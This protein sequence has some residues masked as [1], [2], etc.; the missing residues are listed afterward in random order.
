LT[1]RFELSGGGAGTIL[2]AD[3]TT[4]TDDPPAFGIAAF[5]GGATAGASGEPSIQAGGHPYGFS[6]TVEFHSLLHPT[7][8]FV[9]PV[10]PVES[11]KDVV[12]DLPPGLLGNPT[13]TPRCEMVDLIGV[14]GK[15][16]CSPSTQVGT[17]RLQIAAVPS[18]PPT[19]ISGPVG[20]YN[21]VPP[22]G[23]PARFGFMIKGAAVT[24]NAEV[25]S[26]GDY[27]VTVSAENVSEALAIYQS[28]V[29]LWGVPADPVHDLER[30][31]AGADLP[32]PG[33]TCPAE[34][35]L[36]PFFRDPT[37]CPA[38][39][40]GLPFSARADSWQDPGDFK[41]ASFNTHEL[42]GDPFP[43]SMWGPE[44]GPGECDQLPFEPEISVKPTSTQAASPTGLEVDLSI[45]QEECW[46]EG[47]TVAEIESRV[48]QSDLRDV[49][50]RLPAGMTVNPA[51]ADG[52]GA[53][54]SAQIALDTTADAT[55]PDSS[56]IGKVEVET[57]LLDESLTGSV[58]LAKQF[59]NPFDSLLAMYIVAKGSGVNVKLAG[60]IEVG[61]DGTLTTRFT[62]QPQTP[63]SHLHVEL[64]SGPRA[65]LVNPSRCGTHTVAASLAPWSGTA[66]VELSSPFELSQGPG[67]GPCPEDGFDPKLSAGT[68]SPLG[69]AFSPF[70][71]RLTREDGT[72]VLTGLSATLPEGLLGKLAGVSYCPESALASI[73]GAEG[74]GAAWLSSPACP[75]NSLLGRLT[76]GAGAGPSP[77]FL[78]TGRAYL[79]GPY[80]GA[81]YSLAIVTPAVAGPFDLGSVLVRNA[82]DVDPVTTRISVASDPFPT[83]LHGIPVDLRDVR[84]SIDRPNFTINP[85]SCDPMSIEADISGAGGASA[86][87]SERFQAAECSSLAFKPKL[88]LRLKG[89]TKRTDHP[90]LIASLKARPGDAN[91]DRAQVTLPRAAFLDQA[92]IRTVC[93]RVQFAGDRCPKG[94]VYGRAR[95]TSPLLDYPVYGPVYLRSSDNPLP[96]LV[97][98]LRGPDF[99]PIEVE[100][101]GRTDAVKGAL[102]NTFDFV[103]DAPVTK[104][105]LELFGG[106]RG[107]VVLSRNLCAQT[108]RATVKLDGQNGKTYDTRPA[109]RS[110]CAKKRRGKGR[111]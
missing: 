31:C 12:V 41:S 46:E 44:V 101:S 35:P 94:S 77:F 4:V 86:Q 68:S 88:R 33:L 72:R 56:K 74:A 27:G 20:I 16:T 10:W 76:V 102:R 75:P 3:A 106:R 89:G 49:E 47:A 22:P 26:A 93:T 29:D 58:Y 57:P 19:N 43:P 28:D 21:L 69:G 15:P 65:P 50:V 95:A 37:S 18:G 111:R 109:L 62:D 55:C 36:V 60:K 103:P 34:A 107:L 2:S 6:N 63:F 13:V 84:V 32:L 87:R 92:H 23:V 1:A 48:C 105:A 108:Y 39:G 11:I 104:F 70:G 8:P 67:G 5:D 85:T 7:N 96:D 80:K 51:S 42:P 54:T 52:L 66:P 79:A 91:I 45:P 64:K 9:G 30:P 17:V 98:V 73:S 24:L 90:R 82:L 78:D 53:C 14:E 110:D 97:A 61:P 81:P 71:L 100:L 83:A 99:A 40:T 38:A 59:D 25:R